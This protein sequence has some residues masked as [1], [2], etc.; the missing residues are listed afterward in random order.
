MAEPPSRSIELLASVGEARRGETAG[1]EDEMGVSEGGGRGVK[2]R[3]GTKTM[4]KENLKVANL[5]QAKTS[6][7]L[8]LG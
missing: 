1:L 2:A 7:V 5:W 6:G 3:S 4:E 8:F